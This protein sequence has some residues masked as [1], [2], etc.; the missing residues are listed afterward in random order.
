MSAYFAAFDAWA[1]AN[2]LIMGMVFGFL[3]ATVAPHLLPIRKPFPVI[4]PLALTP[5]ESPPTAMTHEDYVNEWVQGAS[6]KP[7][8]VQMQIFDMWARNEPA[9]RA[10]ENAQLADERELRAAWERIN[11]DRDGQ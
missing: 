1:E 10:K 8:E 5:D 11:L 2:P 4:L 6:S 7:D 9:R 3:L